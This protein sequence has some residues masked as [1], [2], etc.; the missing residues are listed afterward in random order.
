MALTS[1]PV[2][3]NSVASQS[4]SSGCDGHSPC[5]AEIFDGLD[6]A[7]A[8]I[9]LPEAIHGDARQQR[10]AGID[11]PFGEAEAIVRRAGG[12]RRQRGGNAGLHDF[13]GL[14]VCAADQQMRLFRGAGLSAITIT[15]GKVRS[16]FS[17]SARRAASLSQASRSCAGAA[18]S[19]KDQRSDVV[20]YRG[21]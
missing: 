10:I 1:Q 5:D 15:V 12:Q 20:F 16:N 8:E 19:R 21:A 3:M 2:R 4:S 17:L 14:I 18:F 13:A 7:G 6:D 11:Q 9:H